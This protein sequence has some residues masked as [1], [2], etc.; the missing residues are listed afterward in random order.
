MPSVILAVNRFSKAVLCALLMSL[1]SSSTSLAMTLS[2]DQAINDAINSSFEVSIERLRIAQLRADVK[3]ARADYFPTL[4]ATT[5]SEYDRGLKNTAQ[6]VFSVGNT[7]FNGVTRFQALASFQAN[8]TLFDFGVRR[9]AVRAAKKSF[10]AGISVPEIV[11]RDLRLDVIEAY[12]NA[13]TTFKELKAKELEVPLHREL[14]N[15]KNQTCAAGNASR[16]ELTEQALQLAL[17]EDAVR[18]LRELLTSRLRD[19]TS[20]THT[21]YA[22]D[23][24]DME[25]FDEPLQAKVRFEPKATRDFQ[26]FEKQIESKRAELRSLT[27]QRYP[28]V[29]AYSGYVL[30]GTDANSFG[31]ALGQFSA[32]MANAGVTVQWTIFDGLKNAAQCERKKYEIKELETQRDK[33][34]WD[35]KSRYDSASASLEPLAAELTTKA[36]IVNQGQQKIGMYQRLADRKISDRT[37]LLNQQAQLIQ[38]KLAGDKVRIQKATATEKIKVLAGI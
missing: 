9:N 26:R 36:E 1:F 16:V 13:L 29:R 14:F 31:D 32:R 10:E 3:A 11:I 15:I 8:W 17:A 4:V 23:N 21:D 34:L 27:A 6:P 28:Q 22:P 30:Y 38:Q 25:D 2:L 5:S 20:L 37:T 35:L 7:T 24:L 19:L 12:G 33:K 18:H